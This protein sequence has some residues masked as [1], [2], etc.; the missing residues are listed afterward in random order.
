M[1]LRLLTGIPLGYLAALT[2]VY[3]RAFS[4]HLQFLIFAAVTFI[5]LRELLR[6]LKLDGPGALPDSRGV[7][8][9]CQVFYLLLLW[10]AHVGHWD[11]VA[12]W[13]F[14]FFLA[15]ALLQVPRY[16]PG[17]P[18]LEVPMRA[19]F[20]VIYPA[21]GCAA[22]F[23]IR[24][25]GEHWQAIGAFPPGLFNVAGL[26]PLVGTWGYDGCALATGLVLGRTPM[27]PAISP[28]KSWEGFAGGLTG[29]GVAMA[30]TIWWIYK[31]QL[32][33]TP[34]PLAYAVAIV[35]G[36]HCGAV[37]Q[38]GDIF[39]SCLK[40]EAQVKDS[41][42]LIPSQGGILD[43]MDGLLFVLPTVYG[44]LLLSDQWLFPGA[45]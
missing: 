13:A 42:D 9:V 41:A 27:V 23:Q 6:L 19:L 12:L 31:Y 38:L 29:V 21:I 1:G 11:A 24:D 16:V 18:F 45:V 4:P 33:A 30:L 7:A 20:A 37:S 8:L 34:A 3:P 43:K 25:L 28:K 32:H 22:L 5:G 35:I 44:L 40:R 26:F 39:A 36:L 17:Q 10:I 15:L 14:A 2:M